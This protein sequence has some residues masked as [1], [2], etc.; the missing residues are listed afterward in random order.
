MPVSQESHFIG[1]IMY[2]LFCQLYILGYDSIAATL[3][4]SALEDF[5]SENMTEKIGVSEDGVSELNVSIGS[6]RL[7]Q[8]IRRLSAG[9]GNGVTDEQLHTMNDAIKRAILDCYK[10]KPP[11][12]G[13]AKDVVTIDEPRDQSSVKPLTPAD[14][15]D[16]HK[17]NTTDT[18]NGNASAEK[19]PT[20]G[21][22]G[23]PT[24]AEAAK[25]LKHI[26]IVEPKKTNSETSTTNVVKSG[27]HQTAPIVISSKTSAKASTEGSS[28]APLTASGSGSVA[29]ASD[30]NVYLVEFAKRKGFTDEQINQVFT[31]HGK[32]LK[33]TELLNKLRNLKQGEA[34]S[35]TTGLPKPVFPSAETVKEVG[36]QR[37]VPENENR[38]HGHPD[39]NSPRPPQAKRQTTLPDKHL[40]DYI[41]QLFKDHE[42]ED[43]L[44]ITEL[45]ER[46][47]ERQR[48]L[49]D[50]YNKR[51]EEE[52]METVGKG[53]RSKM[54]D[55]KGDSQA[56]GNKRRQNRTSPS[57]DLQSRSVE[58]RSR[59]PVKP[60]QSRT[61]HSHHRSPSPTRQ[62]H[63][64]G[65]QFGASNP[66]AS[67][68]SRQQRPDLRYIVID[69]SNVAYQ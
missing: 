13:D 24:M 19:E 54:S 55:H 3:A 51:S 11:G 1:I 48:L 50:A 2:Y 17:D 64:H 56:T 30:A 26:K 45:K 34:S 31:V 46:N 20:P 69:G 4:M 28:T 57:K 14:F 6:R 37:L 66:A 29:Q 68:V 35:D 21:S 12:K 38:K 7:D 40:Q 32:N 65:P 61:V 33:T 67:A 62:D 39:E 18:S 15:I 23:L 47:A 41:E 42:E 25:Q 60:P 16:I 43:D 8:E 27:Y 9:N 44:S 63:H 59:S 49:V 58:H 10:D 53:A 36:A 52:G 22:A 5:I